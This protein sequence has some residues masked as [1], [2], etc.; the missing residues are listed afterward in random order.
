VSGATEPT[1]GA[2]Q[3]GRREANE[4]ALLEAAESLLD[5]GASFARLR[6]EEIA[7]RAGLGRTNFYFYFGDKR[8]LLRRL[9]EEAAGELYT[10]ADRWWHGEGSA[11]ELGE[12]VAAVIRL[13]MRHGSVLNAV[14]QTAAVDPEVRA[15]WRGLA[16]RFVEA[17]RE[18]IEREQERGVAIGVPAAETAFALVWMTERACYQRVQDGGGDPAALVQALTGIWRRSVYGPL[19]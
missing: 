5:E 18:R 15:V 11:E 7:K 8:A 6:V 16:E 9:A 14:V 1:P 2:E 17:T 13:W 3:P 10:Q 12:I 4:A 19:V